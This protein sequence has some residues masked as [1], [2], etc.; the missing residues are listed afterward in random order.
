MTDVNAFGQEWQVQADEPKL[1]H[2]VEGAQA[3]ATCAMPTAESKK[4]RRLGESISMHDA[5][6]ACARVTNKLEHSACV[7][8]VLATGQKDVAGAY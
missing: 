6:V 3:P 1:F 2:S 8:D 5:E 4:K 7:A